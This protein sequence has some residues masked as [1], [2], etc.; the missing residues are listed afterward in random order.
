MLTYAW[1]GAGLVGCNVLSGVGDL[2]TEQGAVAGDSGPGADG[3][4]EAG[5]DG[6][7]PPALDAAASDA[8]SPPTD[9]PPVACMPS[10]IVESATASPGAIVDDPRIGSVAWTNTLGAKALGGETAR[11]TLSGSAVTHWLLATGYGFA[12]PTGATIRGIVVT[13]IRSASFVDEIADYAVSVVKTG[14]PVGPPKVTLGPWPTMMQTVTYGAPTN[15]WGT[16]W[17]AE[18]VNATDFGAAV[19]ARGTM[20][21]NEMAIVDHIT[22]TVHFE[23]CK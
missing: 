3:A 12:L 21:A 6:G 16:T 13:V 23:R 14:S 18:L 22:V 17:T 10:G 19:A 20:A 2:R 9:G 1:I 15:T 4:V 5:Q 11:A 8:T 7:R